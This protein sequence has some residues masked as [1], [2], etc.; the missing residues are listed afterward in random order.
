M[1]EREFFDGMSQ[2]RIG[3]DLSAPEEE[4]AVDE[5]IKEKP[6]QVA[7]IGSGLGRLLGRSPKSILSKQAN[8]AQKLPTT[9]LDEVEAA[10][11]AT[12]PTEGADRL[13]NEDN[14]GDILN[15]IESQEDLA[16]LLDITGTA[17]EKYTR[18]SFG[19]IEADSDAMK[20]LAP[21]F[22]GEQKGLLT[23][24][25]QYGLRNLAATT[26]NRSVE[27]A[28]LIAAGDHTPELL[29]EYRRAFA[30]FEALYRMAKGNARETA[31]A[32]NQQKMLAKT[33]NTKNLREM[34]DALQIFGHTPNG[35]GI[36]SSAEIIAKRL[37]DGDSS[38][39]A[40]AY[41]LGKKLNLYTRGLVELWKN[42]ILSGL[43]TH[44]VN[45][46]SVAVTNLWENL[47][48][49]PVA[50]GIGT[51]RRGATGGTDGVRAAELVYQQAGAWIGFRSSLGMFADA[52]KS[53]ESKFGAM[54]KMEDTGAIR[55]I[56]RELTTGSQVGETFADAATISFRLLQAEDDA[57]RGIVFTS[58]LYALAAR[59]ARSNGFIGEKL[60]NR[61]NEILDNPT[62][63]MYDMAMAE[64]ARKTFTKGDLKGAV[65]MMAK[66][67]RALMGE[68]PALQFIL[69][70][71]NTPANL[72]Q[73]GMD[74]SILAAVS[75]RL[76][77]EVAKGGASAD[78]ALAKISVGSSLTI[79]LWQL[80]EAGLISGNGPDDPAARAQ[81]EREGWKP[82]AVKG[83]NGKWYQVKRMEPFSTTLAF[84]AN[85][86]D[87]AKYAP[88]DKDARDFMA[89]AMLSVAE[90][91]MDS[92]WT[93]GIYD[94]YEAVGD[95]NKWDRFQANYAASFIP[96]SAAIRT[97]EQMY[98]P[99]TAKT[100]DDPLID[101]SA[102]EL[103][104]DRIRSSTPFLSKTLRP[105]RYW[106][107]TVMMPDQGG[108]AFAL[109][110]IKTGTVGKGNIIN[111]ELIVNGVSLQE[112]SSVLKLG[113]NSFS[114]LDIAGGNDK[115]YDQYIVS[116]GKARVEILTKV[117]TKSQYMKLSEGPNGER[118]AI[119]QKAAMAAKR[120]GTI[121]F[122][123]G[124]L[125]FA[126]QGDSDLRSRAE[127]IFRADPINF[128]KMLA[129]EEERMGEILGLDVRR[130]REPTRKPIELPNKGTTIPYIPR[131]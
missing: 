108:F 121:D 80:Y 105:A 90:T 65:G 34:G 72:L 109:S 114:L 120:K 79:G 49:R 84:V 55:A 27:L 77:G 127:E 87:K 33:L 28:K 85:A 68:V 15:T 106:D 61:V 5:D 125:L 59:D 126:L 52:F 53:G 86:L 110:P 69:P 29:L 56:A 116:V 48:I 88:T 4:V 18:Q 38:T 112:P 57:M 92:A 23:A 11:S 89:H 75:P 64:A 118:Y 123:K 37:K 81:L 16:R 54:Q 2:F 63:E 100:S 40:M 130:K 20:D 22:K 99:T 17:E 8:K 76:W 104:K 67:T 3:K 83:P 35:D 119:L 13:I 131:F 30:A 93:A 115:L 6:T 7:G 14:L 62:D 97:A 98:D 36:I 9:T 1:N 129:K 96:Y 78:M 117:V 70:F 12:T 66:Y 43:G 95:V 19:D 58:E 82:N 102:F 60:L 46:S 44:A 103:T 73:Y 25:Q 111:R 32:L 71:V 26:G 124:D 128:I 101:K 10:V 45:L 74:T 31:R 41:V 42:N 113:H 94:F 122:L 91:A 39:E 107:G 21:L 24:K 51:I 50:L 47:A